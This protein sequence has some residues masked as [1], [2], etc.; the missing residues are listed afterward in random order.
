VGVGALLIGNARTRQ[1]RVDRAYAQGIGSAVSAYTQAIEM[2]FGEH[3]L[4]A[5]DAPA[6]GL[7][8]YNAQLDDWI[9]IGEA[10]LL[11]AQTGR[12]PDRV[13]VLV[14]GLDEPGGIWD[15]LAPALAGAGHTVVRF[16]YAN[17]QAIERSASR[18][19]ESLD[20]LAQLGVERVDLV[21]H[22]MG[23]L[24]AYDAIT[25]DG[26]ADHGVE[27][28]RWVTIGTPFG[29]SPWARLRAVSEI[30][31]QVQRWIESD[32][33][34]PKRLLGFVRD[35]VGQAGTDLLPGSDFL[36]GLKERS[37]P[38]GIRITHIVG[39]TL[40]GAG[41]DLGS[42]VASGVLGDLVGERDA[43]VIQS[44]LD[45]L[46]RELGDGV[47]P[48]S[49]AVLE[50]VGDVVVLQANHRGMIRTVELS[51]AIRQ[52]SG[53]PESDEPMGIAVVLDRLKRE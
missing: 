40:P 4:G 21:C 36:V 13:V 51:E 46:A 18:F 43:G 38:G 26:F 7:L 47:V 28:E 30:R 27:L 6:R 44:E 39:R 11:D 15:Q 23:G 17:D 52:V 5:L 53:L 32:D 10:E 45:K 2:V 34:D 33:L 8:V 16:E 3:G 12:T 37:L 25:R 31:E 41:M 24:V 35:G 19:V 42:L 29:G 48:M 20:Q 49:S 9:G 22:S 1:L 14:H 50:G